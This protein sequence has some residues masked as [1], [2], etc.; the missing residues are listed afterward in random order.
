MP[1]FTMSN[2]K[3][4]ALESEYV[5][6]SKQFSLEN[7]DAKPAEMFE[8]S[9]QA[10]LRSEDV[11]QLA[12]TSL[13]FLAGL[14]MPAV[15]KYFFPPVFLSIWTWLLSFVHK[16]RDFSQLAIG[17]PRG[18]GKTMLIKLFIVY[19]ILFTKK[20]F[21]L[22]ICGTQT[23]ANNIIS[24]I[25]SMLSE[26]NVITVFGFWKVGVE[27]DRQELKR[28]NYRGRSVILM[29]AGAQSDIRGI[30]LENARPD[31]MIFDDIQTREE[32]DS[33]PVS[34]NIETWMTGTAMKSKSPHGCLFVF[35][36]NMYP[37]KWSLLR[38]L[39][40]NPTWTKF[41]AGG[42][43]ADGT[44]LWEDLQPIS[45]LLKEFENDLAMG[46][47]EIFFSEVLNDENAS[48]NNLLDLSNLPPFPYSP[49][50]I[51]L[52]KYIIID[53]SNDR[54]GSDAVSIML[55]E[56]YDGRPVARKLKEGRLSPG[57]TITETLK[58]CL[59]NNCR[60]IA[61]EAN[62]YQAT[63][64]YWFKFICAQRQ[65]VGIQI[66]EMYSG[67]DNKN[68]RIMEMFNQLR[69]GELFV[70]PDCAPAVNLQIVQFNPLRSDNTDGL[71]DCLTYGPKVLNLHQQL[72]MSS[73][74]IEDQAAGE[75]IVMDEL[76]N[77]AF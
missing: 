10:H 60:I 12:K 2:A 65:I 77:S 73:N 53:P 32:A 42:I 11:E 34:R 5:A 38:R 29:G 45:Q 36:A 40:T 43:L 41:I 19:C 39:K 66:V 3:I 22:I 35:I 52:G 33:E 55:F 31:V 61:I 6:D 69:T 57:E 21:I 64:G 50:D 54:L 1:D 14:V 15:F 72:I 76:S 30:T 4:A 8:E 51:V 56:V 16:T 44:S 37:T 46:R 20:Q 18:F 17:L 67:R 13:D 75:I 23:K 58:L 28:F 25:M 71:L 62:A 49:N 24:D 9:G 27:S 68:S 26:K 47:P 74:I 63:L 48:V 59:E 7:L 70:H